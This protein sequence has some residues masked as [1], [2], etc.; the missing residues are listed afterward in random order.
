MDCLTWMEL[1][2]G[3]GVLCGWLVWVFGFWFWLLWFD[4]V[5]LVVCGVGCCL[6]C[7]LVGL[8]Y[9]WVVV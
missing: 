5:L 2:F 4:L 1:G 6:W 3:M 7:G 9:F 8:F